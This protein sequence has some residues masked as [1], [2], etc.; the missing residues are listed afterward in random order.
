MELVEAI[1]ARKSI[2]GFLPEP[3]P[4]QV[5]EEILELAARSPSW[6]N[7][8]PWEVAVIGREVMGQVKA[9]FLQAITSGE[10]PNP[11]IPYASFDE[12]YVSRS[13]ALGTRLYQLLGI[14]REDREKRQEWALRGR[15]FF[16]APDGLIFYMDKGLGEWS[17][18]DLGIFSQSIMLA[19]VAFGLGSCPLA[20]VMGYPDI[21]RS[22]LDIPDTKKIVY[23]MAIGYPDW[24]QPVNTLE[25][26]R[27][28]V[29]SFTQWRGF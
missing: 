1:R 8:Q 16:D 3:V 23:G 18:F 7:T 29:S 2:R 21:L 10:P 13:R 14:G 28:P 22:I 19:A 27:E 4:K 11:D 17:L 26:S 5:L 20:A 24:Q 25:S 12:P 9:A 6:G 15:I